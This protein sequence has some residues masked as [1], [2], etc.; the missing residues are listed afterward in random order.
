[1]AKNNVW[2]F[3]EKFGKMPFFNPTHLPIWVNN[4]GQILS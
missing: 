4:F 3:L 2:A 1:L